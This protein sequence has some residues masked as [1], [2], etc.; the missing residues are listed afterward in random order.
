M[1]YKPT[2][3][4]P[5]ATD[6]VVLRGLTASGRHPPNW[7][8]PLFFRAGAERAVYYYFI[9]LLLTQTESRFPRPKKLKRLPRGPTAS[10]TTAPK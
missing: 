8:S 5:R 4:E 10:G 9:K 2:P 3:Y 6:S 7:E 1:P